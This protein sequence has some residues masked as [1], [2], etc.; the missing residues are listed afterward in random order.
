MYAVIQ[1]GGK[2][3]RV[4]QGETIKIEKL[5]G[6]VG[7]SIDFSDVLLVGEGDSVQIGHPLLASAKVSGEIL[8]QGRSKKIIIFHSKRRKNHRKKNGHR[9]PFTLIRIS[10]ISA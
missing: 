3:Y 7:K 2:Q 10:T 6:D 4:A 5:D 1:T 8:E 9:Q